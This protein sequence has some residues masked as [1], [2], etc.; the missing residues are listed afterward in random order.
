MPASH[1]MHTPI[2][3]HEVRTQKAAIAL[4][5]VFVSFG[6]LGF[7]PGITTRYDQLAFASLDSGARLF[8]LFAVSVVCNLVHLGFGLA[9]L[10][11]GSTFA[12]ARRFLVGGGIAYL[13]LFANGAVD[14]YAYDKAMGIDDLLHL[15]LSVLMIALGTGFACPRRDDRHRI[16]IP[17]R[18]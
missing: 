17:D 3:T 10:V 7:V 14:H 2:P 1:P 5:A 9:G 16:V 4:G 11:L 13:A 18:P 12:R 8:G 15:G 6:V